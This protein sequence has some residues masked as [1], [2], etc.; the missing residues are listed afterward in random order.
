MNGKMHLTLLWI[1]NILNGEFKCDR[2]PS[3][4]AW[5]TSLQIK[6]CAEMSLWPQPPAAHGICL[7]KLTKRWTNMWAALT[8]SEN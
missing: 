7:K 3:P 4:A 1:I 5:E 2:A 6:I 8:T